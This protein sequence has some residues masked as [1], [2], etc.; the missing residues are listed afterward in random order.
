V[1]W[2]WFICPAGVISC[3]ALLYFMS[4][5]NWLL[6]IIWTVMGLA[7]YFGYGIRHS[8]LHKRPNQG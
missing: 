2:A 8:R 7:I 6:M 1:P 5:F 3:L 4:W